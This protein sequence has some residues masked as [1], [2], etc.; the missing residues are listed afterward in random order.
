MTE[1]TSGEFTYGRTKN[2]GDYNNKKVEIKLA[3]SVEDNKHAEAIA[4]VSGVAIKACEAILEGKATP[5][6]LQPSGAT[7]AAAPAPAPAPAAG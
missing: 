2:L 6:F 5:A 1:I 4:N 3:F 7:Q